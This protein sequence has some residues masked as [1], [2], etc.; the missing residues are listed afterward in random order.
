MC[1]IFFSGQV[2]KLT[3]ASS[4]FWVS[5]EGDDVHHEIV[6][7]QEEDDGWLQVGFIV[8]PRGRGK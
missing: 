6:L 3:K 5:S 2:T 8:L 4:Y 7:S 1:T